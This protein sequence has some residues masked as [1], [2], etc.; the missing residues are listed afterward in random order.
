MWYPEGESE[1][2]QAG[3]PSWGPRACRWPCRNN[4]PAPQP[5]SCRRTHVAGTSVQNGPESE[6]T[7]ADGLIRRKKHLHCPCRLITCRQRRA[8]AERPWGQEML[9][10]LGGGRGTQN[11]K[12]SHLPCVSSLPL[13]SHNLV[14]TRTL[15]LSWLIKLSPEASLYYGHST[16]TSE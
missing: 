8:K 6:R 14:L 10:A 9:V 1:A 16:A 4:P 3:R 7:K 2:R 12:Q 13:D 5:V 15:N 11:L